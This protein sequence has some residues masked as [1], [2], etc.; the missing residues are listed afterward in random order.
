MGHGQSANAFGEENDVPHWDR[1][2]HLKTQ[3]RVSH[4][5]IY[6]KRK[7]EEEVGTSEREKG[8][9][10]SFLLVGGILGLGILV[11]SLVFEGVSGKKGR[12]E[13]R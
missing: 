9:L 4:E 6:R 7:G 2:G 13:E 5:R 12:K 8:L 3:R 10:P 1:K 11:P